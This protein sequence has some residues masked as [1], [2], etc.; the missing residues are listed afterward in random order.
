MGQARILGATLL[1]I[2]GVAVEVE[3]RISSQLPR[4][5]IVGLPEA[6]VRESA[7]R[8]R[9]AIR[10]VG[11]TFPQER[12]TINLAPAA[13]RKQGAGLDL[14]IAVG[15]LAA[16]GQVPMES[17]GSVGLVG[18]L[19]LDGR[20]RSVRGALA[21]AD[22]LARGGCS[23]VIVPSANGFETALL[24]DA[25]PEVAQHLS[26]VVEALVTA[27][28]LPVASSESSPGAERHPASEAPDLS[29]VRGQD[30][31][32]RALVVAAAGGHGLLFR[33]APGAG[34]TLLARCLPSLLPPLGR[35]EALEVA[36][37]HAAAG[38]DASRVA[39]RR[40]RPFRAPHHSAS[41]AGLLGGGRQLGPGEATLAH[42]GVL[43]LDELPEF[44]RRGLE[45]LRQVL[46]EG[47]VVHA[48]AEQRVVLPADLQLLAAANPCVCGYF[49]SGVR[50]CRCDDGALARYERRL[51]GPLLDRIDLHVP[52]RPVRFADLDLTEV[53]PLES[54]AL[55]EEVLRARHVQAVRLAGL[56]LPDAM[57][58]NA[59]IPPGSLFEATR[60]TREARRILAGAVDQLA[61][62]ARAAHRLL[63]VA[64]TISDLEGD[65]ETPAAAMAEAVGYRREGG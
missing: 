36:R 32:K 65:E 57:R 62:S 55:R 18:E 41:R 47:R 64:R 33:G 38:L 2:E 13:V 10:A 30:E 22:R 52:V 54:A 12:V 21:L 29:S 63:R 42:R 49:G 15:I 17:L 26:Q 44:D 56:G 28:A 61:L 25:A 40:E 5:D 34:K 51:S 19:A 3:V 4:I 24:G 23:R 35:S 48:R 1:G 59:R 45:A 6:A 8:V 58:C 20:I 16:A 37:I 53:P 27:R 60:P 39:E 9:A 31:A 46:E 7:A 50:D 43:F 14:A 11:F